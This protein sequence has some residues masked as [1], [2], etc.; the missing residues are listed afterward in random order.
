MTYCVHPNCH[1]PYNPDEQRVCRNC[2]TKLLLK[3]RYHATQP[4]ANGKFIRV[5]QGKDTSE[6]RNITIKQ[7]LLPNEI[8]RDSNKRKK[9]IR[10]FSEA[11]QKLHALKNVPNLHTPIDYAVV[12]HGIYLI[13]DILEGERLSDIVEKQ[14]YLQEAQVQNMLRDLLLSLQE[15]HK[16]SFIHR[17]IRPENIIYSFK[18]GQFTLSNFGIPQLVVETL[19]EDI[20]T[21]SE[22]S[23]G[24][25]IYS[26]PEQI[27]CKSIP[28]SDLYSLGL[29]CLQ[30]LT[31][32]EPI[33]L[34]DYQGKD[35][36]YRDYLKNNPVSE[37]LCGTLDK[38]IES[39]IINRFLTAE[40]ILTHL[41]QIQDE[42]TY[43]LG[44]LDSA[45]SNLL[46][47]G[48][49]TVTRHMQLIHSK[50][51]GLASLFL[52]QKKEKSQ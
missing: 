23:I 39:S 32:V 35:W 17:N 19:R 9:A 3:V 46:S 4:V 14:H 49:K 43:R 5:F 37:S 7:I 50:T 44:V 47:S 8:L 10:V 36:H 21:S 30:V 40:N 28:A 6:E 25:P 1:E 27:E 24:D 48:S 38:M 33:H 11:T 51:T 29:V 12:G 31:G 16:Q 13:E 41:S 45:F 2:G 15:L 20:P 42:S 26:A 34:V 52:K 22:Y 18:T